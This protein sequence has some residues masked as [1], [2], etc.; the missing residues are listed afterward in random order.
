MILV[1][2]DAAEVKEFLLLQ[3]TV[4]TQRF[5]SVLFQM[6]TMQDLKKLGKDILKLTTEVAIDIDGIEDSVIDGI[7]L[8]FP[9]VAQG[10]FKELNNETLTRYLQK[11]EQIL[12]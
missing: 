8:R 12:V 2:K 5:R 3:S 4:K 1:E 10:I 7:I 11:R 6:A 9:V